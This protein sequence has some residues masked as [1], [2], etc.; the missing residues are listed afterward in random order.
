MS[1][2]FFFTYKL[3]DVIWTVMAIYCWPFLSLFSV[4]IRDEP[5]ICIFKLQQ[6]RLF[7]WVFLNIQLRP[8]M[9]SFRCFFIANRT[10][11][12]TEYRNIFSGQNTILSLNGIYEPSS[13]LAGVLQ[14]PVRCSSV[15]LLIPKQSY[16]IYMKLLCSENFIFLLS[17]KRLADIYCCR[18]PF[19]FWLTR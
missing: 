6:Q 1:F 12:P 7:L 18:C 19:S 11:F 9:H 5:L 3:L 4:T 8:H 13:D 16:Y 17:N 15:L 10:V 14:F 2:V